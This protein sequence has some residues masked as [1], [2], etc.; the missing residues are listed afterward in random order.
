MSDINRVT[1]IGRLT[2]E[3]ELKHVGTGTACCKF[4]LANNRTYTQN[5]E[6]KEEVSFFN[7]VSWG[8]QAEIVNQYCRQGQQV[9]IEGRLKSSTWQDKEGKT[10]TGVDIVV[11]SLQMIGDRKQNPVGEQQRAEEQLKN[12]FQGERVDTESID[13]DDDIPF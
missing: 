5:G 6:R 11:D 2:R 7:C 12:T 3:P 9:A 13:V 10:K 8:K 4:S 1:L